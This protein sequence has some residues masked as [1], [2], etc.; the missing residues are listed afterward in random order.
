[1]Q[2]QRGAD[3][4]HVRKVVTGESELGNV[5]VQ[6]V[7][8]GRRT[9]RPALPLLRPHP[10]SAQRL[11]YLA[12]FQLPTRQQLLRVCTCLFIYESLHKKTNKMLRQK[13]SHR[14]AVQ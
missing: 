12:P 13:Q 5:L 14:S 9:K 1:M 2:K 10:L 6:T 4:A 8:S 11:P 7:I 3:G